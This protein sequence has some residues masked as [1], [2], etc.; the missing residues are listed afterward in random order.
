[1]RALRMTI[2]IGEADRYEHR[3][4]YTAILDRLKRAGCGGATVTRGVAGFGAH[5]NVIKT[6]NILRLS[7]DLP[8]VITTVD[9]AEKIESLLPELSAMLTGGLVTIEETQI[10]YH[11]AAFHGGLPR[12]RVGDVMNR[13]P[14]SVTME[15]AIAE[16]VQRLLV[17]DYTALPVVDGE[18]RVIGVISDGDMLRAGLT[19][20]SVSLHKATDPAVVRESLARLE[21]EGGTVRELMTS[22]AVTLKPETDLSAAAHVM[23]TRRLKRLPV[24]DDQGRLVGVLGRLDI[25]QSIASGYTRRTVPLAHR[26]PQEHRTVAEIMERDVPTVAE[27][28][29][30]ADVVTKLLDS[31][32]K[33]VLVTDSAGRPSGFISDTD[34]VARV[35]PAERPGLLAQLRSRWNAEIAHKVR[36]SYGQ[37]AVDVMTTPVLTVRDTAPVIEALS[38]TVDRH[39]KRVPVVDAEGRVVGIVSRPALLAAS[40]AVAAEEDAS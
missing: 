33:R 27:T 22:P 1:M 3:P 10:Y 30:L 17:R 8:I 9:A 14:E 32:V 13:E 31:D 18:Q 16:V 24:V 5:S 7:I 4:L 12:L 37:R 26:L 35:D 28:A 15:T 36:R 40:L 6:A 38:L 29:T 11:S 19:R 25:L 2:F 20:L 23:H 39:V 34:I 21:R